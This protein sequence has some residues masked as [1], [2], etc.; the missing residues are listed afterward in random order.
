MDV[1]DQENYELPTTLLKPEYSARGLLLY[2]GIVKDGNYFRLDWELK[3]LKV[4]IPDQVFDD[5]QLS[6]TEEPVDQAW[7]A[8]D[9]EII[10]A[11]YE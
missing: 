6:D 3:Q 9:E 7:V 5:C 8:S 4:R 1:Y 2:K 11:I 10:E